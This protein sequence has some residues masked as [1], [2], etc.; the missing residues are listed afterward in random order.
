MIIDN[1]GRKLELVDVPFQTTR[2][3]CDRCFYHEEIGP[4]RCDEFLTD[5]QCGVTKV[6]QEVK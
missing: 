4:E 1:A 5:I 2:H 6:Y 3:C